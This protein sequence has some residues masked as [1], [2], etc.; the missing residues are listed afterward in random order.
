[1]RAYFGP[2]KEITGNNTHTPPEGNYAIE[3]TD[4]EKPLHWDHCREQFAAKFTDAS[5]PG[6]FFSHPD[7]KG[8]DIANFLT[9]FEHITF[10]EP[11]SS[12]AHTNRENILWVQVAPFWMPCLIKRS[13]LTILL[14]CG[15][16]YDS[17]KDNFDD[18]LFGEYKE[19]CYLKE[20]R[21][22]VLRFMFGFT[23]FSGRVPVETFQSS[24]IKYGWREEFHKVD[25]VGV[26]RRL[27]L[28]TD[29][30][31]E[32]NIVGAESLWI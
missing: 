8:V 29:K 11:V 21:S 1:M 17:K 6:F 30:S 19:S 15:I 12:F 3:P 28:P 14:R 4:A 24:I 9:K 13:L 20:T 27:I 16:N 26:R 10:V 18:A 2:V 31:K 22:A 5:R 7:S 23:E 25:D 32:S